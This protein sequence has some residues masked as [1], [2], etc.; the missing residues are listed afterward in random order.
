MQKKT[1]DLAMSFTELE[2]EVWRISMAESCL[3]GSA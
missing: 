1:S 3:T 2:V